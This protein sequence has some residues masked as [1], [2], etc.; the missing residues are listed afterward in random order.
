MVNIRITFPRLTQSLTK[1]IDQRLFGLVATGLVTAPFQRIRR[2]FR[3]LIANPSS[4]YSRYTRLWFAGIPSRTNI[5][6]SRRYPNR[7]RL[8]ASSFN[9]V[10]SAPS[11]SA[12]RAR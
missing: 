11:R 5:A 1:S 7:M 10:R 4:R 8:A 3:I 6:V 9:R 2:R 12:F